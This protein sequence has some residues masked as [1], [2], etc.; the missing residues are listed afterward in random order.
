MSCNCRRYSRA[1]LPSPSVNGCLPGN[2]PPAPP[3]PP[4]SAPPAVHH[5]WMLRRRQCRTRRGREQR[6]GGQEQRG[7]T[8]RSLHAARVFWPSLDAINSFGLR[9]DRGQRIPC[10]ATA[11]PP[12]WLLLPFTVTATLEASSG[13]VWHI[14]E[15]RI[16]AWLETRSSPRRPPAAHLGTARYYG[17]YPEGIRRASGGYPEVYWAASLRSLEHF[18]LGGGGDNASAQQL[19]GGPHH[20]VVGQNQSGN[21]GQLMPGDSGQRAR[22]H[23]ERTR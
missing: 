12:Q 21:G 14:A 11:V 4:E 9:R 2:A 18:G 13:R 23:G 6:R 7:Q 10:S 16:S 15:A 20:R 1:A 22:G 8:E 17:W 3:S 5:S 19:A